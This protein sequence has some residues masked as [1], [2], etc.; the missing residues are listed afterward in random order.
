MKRTTLSMWAVLAAVVVLGLGIS[1]LPAQNVVGLGTSYAPYDNFH[2][3]FL[4]P[5]RWSLYGACWTWNVL[6]CVREIQN[7]SL[8]LEVK[9]FGATNSNDGI[10]YGFDE[11]HFANPAPIRRIAAQLTVRRASVDACSANAGTQAGQSLIVGTF[12]NSG[13][14]DPNDDV[15]A[16]LDIEHYAGDPPGQLDALGFLYWEGQFFG[17]VDLGHPSVG[18]TLIAQLIW[19][20]PNHQFV[21][22]WTDANTGKMTQA[23]MPY[24]M[25]DLMQ[26]AAPDR[27]LAVRTFAPNCVGGC[28]KS[29]FVETRF[30]N[31]WIGK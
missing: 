16:F 28:M 10:G 8:R 19:D 27:F 22:S 25:P 31:V 12:F 23:F 5:S 21:V 3:P 24:S 13:S 4:D 6:E 7:N 26:A 2:A 17:G 11:L 29:A 14:G 1:L 15:Q 20:Q 9:S 18:E 30:Y